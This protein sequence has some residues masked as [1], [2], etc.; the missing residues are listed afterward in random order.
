MTEQGPI[1]VTT[2]EHSKAHVI[3]IPRA[4][5]YFLGP[6]AQCL[7]LVDPG[8]TL[9]RLRLTVHD[10]QEEANCNYHGLKTVGLKKLMQ[11]LSFNGS[12]WREHH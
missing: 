5:I 7:F 4:I 3:P 1:E 11:A 8:A 10:P 2:R 12:T 9:H 6:K